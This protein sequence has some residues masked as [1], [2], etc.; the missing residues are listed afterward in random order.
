MPIS[1][2]MIALSS[3]LVVAVADKLPAF[4]V[5]R[6]CKLDLAATAGLSD[7]QSQKACV[8]D[9]NRAKQQLG[10]QWP[11]FSPASKTQCISMESVGGTPSYVSLQTCL[12]MDAWVKQR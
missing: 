7:T 12:Q 11:K 4:D 3:Q 1:I 6:T 8:M 5:A 2:S 10:S 9:E